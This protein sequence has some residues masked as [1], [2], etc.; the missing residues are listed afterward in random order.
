MTDFTD[1]VLDDD[2]RARMQAVQDCGILDSPAEEAFDRITALAARL[3]AVPF[4]AVSIIDTDRIWFKSSYGLPAIAE[5]PRERGLCGS[6]V[7]HTGPWVLTDASS[8]AAA[9]HN[10]FVAGSPGV[11]FYAG[12]PLSG[13]GGKTLAL[14]V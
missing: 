10:A 11:R 13:P 1:G 2:E 14:S 12:V 3:F 6:A 5:T 4:A 7:L 8:D 9:V